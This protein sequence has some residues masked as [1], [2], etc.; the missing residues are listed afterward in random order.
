MADPGVCCF[1]TKILCAHGG[2]MTLDE[3][4][5]EIALPEPELRDLLLTAGPDRFVLVESGGRAGVASSVVATTRARVCRRKYCQSHCE[6]LHLCKLNLLGRCHYSQAE[7]N[8]CKYSHEVLSEENFQVLKHH[9]LSGLNKKELAVLLVQSDPFFMPEICKTY[10][11]EGRKQICSQQLPCERLHICDHFTRGNCGYLNCLRS[12]NL[13]DRKVLAIMRDHGL[14]PDVVQ[15][16]QDI[17]DNKHARKN[18][19]DVRGPSAHRRGAARGRSKSRDR[20]FHGSHEFL[21]AASASQRSSPDRT[22]CEELLDDKPVGDLTY[23]FKYLGSQDHAQPSSVSSKVAGLGG[24]GPMGGS[25]KFSE[26][27]G[28]DGPFYRNHS[29]SSPSRAATAASLDSIPAREAAPIRKGMISTDLKGTSGFADGVA[30]DGKSTRSSNYRATVN[31]QRERTVPSSY[32]NSSAS[33]WDPQTT[34]RNTDDDPG[35]TFLNGKY[36]GT[37]VWAGPSVHSVSNGSSQILDEIP[38]VDAA[39]ATG[40]GLKAAVTRGKEALY[41]G[42]QNLRGQV[43]ASPTAPAQTSGLPQSPLPSP[44]HKAAAP[45]TPGQKSAH[46]AVSPPSGLSR[47]TPVSDQNFTSHSTGS[48]SS[49]MDDH[50]SKEICPDYLLQGCQLR[51]CNKIHFH[52]P[53][54]WQ[55]LM[56]STWTDFGDMEKIEQAYCDPQNQNFLIGNHQIDFQKMTCGVNPVRR[57]STAST[58]SEQANS[59]FNTKWLWYWKSKSGKWIQYGEEDGNQPSSNI[60]SSYLESFFQQSHSKGVVPFQAGSRNYEL[61]FQGMIQTNILSKTQRDVIRRPLFISSQDVQQMKRWTEYQPVNTQAEALTSSFLPQRDDS[62]SSSA[63]RLLELNSQHVEY[64]KISEC[65]KASMKNFKIEKIKRIW[66]PRLLEAFQRRK[67]KMQKKDEVLLFHAASRAHVYSICV[68]NFDWTIHE[69]HETK[70]G[71]GNYFAKEAFYSHKNCPYDSR[72]IIMFV[73]RVL[74][75]DFIEGHMLYRRPPVQYDS[76]VDTRLNPSVFVIFEKDQIYPEYLIEY[77][78]IDKPCVIS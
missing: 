8:L 47:G 41:S 75:G 51:N 60:D 57:M 46:T 45:G 22:G 48:S 11:G 15:N 37:P 43:P 12:H 72:N 65:F 77:T 31:G 68:D 59:V 69:N 49:R 64:I 25:Q 23:K 50:G 55:V 26:N 27:G 20:F 40:F 4:L 44:S 42:G 19:A 5:G 35:V 7:R 63:Y 73:A 54:R 16:I 53:Y 34:S 62:S 30:M 39:G 29:E 61:S 78:E 33:P 38:K 66:N 58:V 10:K 28:L 3:L 1:I 9:Q 32:Q 76:C 52:L 56:S 36:R 14:S 74:V 21:P 24:P 2:R 70:Y 18:H 13:M 67:E 17:C 71:K 6:N